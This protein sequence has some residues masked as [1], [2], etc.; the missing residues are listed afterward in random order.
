MVGNRKI[1]INYH[2]IKDAVTYNNNLVYSGDTFS[3]R[4]KIPDEQY[5]SARFSFAPSQVLDF[6]IDPQSEEKDIIVWLSHR[7]EMRFEYDAL[8]ESELEM[9]MK[10]R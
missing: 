10:V 7:G 9:I 2:D 6:F 3:P 8:L 5:V 1:C 4:A